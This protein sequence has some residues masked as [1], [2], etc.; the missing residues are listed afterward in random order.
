M[1]IFAE[2]ACAVS[3]PKSYRE[4]L[5]DRKGKTFLFGFLLVLI[6]FLITIMIP[7]ARFQA[8]TGG[9][10]H[11]VDQFV[12]DFTIENCQVRVSR[13]VEYQDNG[14][15]VFVDTDRTFIGDGTSL[16]SSGSDAESM[17]QSC[18]RV[19]LMD[20]RQAV[21]KSN[22]QIQ[23]IAY[24]NLD[25]EAYMTKETLLESMK[26]IVNIIVVAVPAVILIGMELLFFLGV[27]F[28]A[29]LGMI[30]ASCMQCPLTFGQLYK[31]GVY[32]RTAPLLLKAFL[33]FLPFGIPMFFVISLCIS[34][35]Y[36]GAGIR[37]IKN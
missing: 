11:M 26:G 32:S 22:G 33:S 24:E 10:L 21:L 8:S 19:L 25:S 9:I 12:P 31:L 16:G 28:V 17:L 29:L 23:Q 3:S 1:N 14:I 36:I 20:A 6:Y 27:V 18:D 4:F 7:F 2:M 13:P 15:Y 30:V 34:L 5:K 35:C 37:H